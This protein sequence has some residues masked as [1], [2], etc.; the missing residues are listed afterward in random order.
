MK[1][2]SVIMPVSFEHHVGGN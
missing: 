2:C 1:H